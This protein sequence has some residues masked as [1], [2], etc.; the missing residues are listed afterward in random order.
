MA[1]ITSSGIG[2]GLDVAG[3]VTQLMAAE[4]QPLVA[5]DRKEVGFQAQLSAY[6]TFKGSLSAFQSSMAGL[7][8]ISKFR[9]FKTTTSD[10]T[11]VTASAAST[12]ANGSYAIEVTQLAQAQKLRSKAFA[13][14]T[15]VV[16]TGT[17]TFQFGKYS[18]GIFT[19]NSEKSSS[20]VTI[21]S[22]QNSLSGIRD[23]VNSANFGVT[24]TILNDGSGNRLVFTSKD[25]GENNGI[26]LTVADTSDASNTDDAG[27]SQLAYD[28]AG[29]AGN[30]KNL[31]ESVVAQ[32]AAFK[33][34]G[35]SVSKATNVVSDVI[36]GVTLN[37][38][39]VSAA[40]TT[41]IVDVTRD[42]EAVKTSINA[43]VK[44]YNDIY[45]TVKDLTAYNAATKQG[46]ILQGD[47]SALSVL[48]QIRR[49]L[50]SSL[51]GLSGAYS[52]LS[53]IGVSFQKDGTIA[54]DSTKLQ[55]AIDTNFNDIA[56]LL[57]SVGKPS[58][59][60][61][62]FLGA[63]D[64]SKP[65]SYAISV[66]QL[67]TQG[68]K[69][70]AATAA[71]ADTAGTFTTPFVVDANNDTFTLKLDNTLSGTITLTQGSYATAAALTAEI[72]SK[73]NAD[74]ALKTA[75]A[76]VVVSFDSAT[77]ILKLTSNRYGATSAAEV[78]AVDTNTA[79]TLGFSVG[80]GTV[81]LDVVGK[82]NSVNATGSGR[83]L[84]GA[85][86]DASEGLK[87]E[88]TGTATGSR[89]VLDYTQGHAYRL[90]KLASKMLE[91]SGPIASR[92]EGINKSI[93]DL[94][95]H[96]EVLIER[97]NQM[98]K[99]YRTQFTSLD[100]LLAK[101]RSTSDYLTR[102]LATLSNIKS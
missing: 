68:T 75:A 67:A 69:S 89:G 85:T 28:P 90:D 35:I 98:E 32:N 26:K 45:K 21:S 9:G 51:T 59:S 4:R 48:S 86:G 8:N 82:I 87:L 2:S 52:S 57:A 61:V 73:I 93:K 31:T 62:N 5:L 50:N 92:V 39:K 81:G 97:F 20:T 79:T 77:D 37:L 91:S 27:L 53:E 64:K 71:L 24:A 65:G 29:T 23:A 15:S 34:D 70:G 7:G 54:L 96:R 101:M 12:A 44:S 46:A 102:Q 13:E 42:T 78:V 11:V 40:S 88:I 72:Q 83:F 18:G 33:V 14:V 17:L 99:R 84:T 6:G 66:S 76:S 10:A 100:G 80:T 74:S 56:G 36:Q 1:S 55:K 16:G 43:F 95:K 49:S 60:L 3:L 38:L 30:G 22:A 41:A 25:S 58:D 19:A 63:T 94:S 47:G